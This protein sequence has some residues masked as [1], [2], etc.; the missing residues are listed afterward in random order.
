MQQ[1]SV[2]RI[3][4]KC[5]RSYHRFHSVL[6]QNDSLLCNSQQVDD[7]TSSEL[8]E[9]SRYLVTSAEKCCQIDFYVSDLVEMSKRN[10]S[11][12]RLKLCNCCAFSFS[13]LLNFRIDTNRHTLSPILSYGLPRHQKFSAI[14]VI[15]RKRSITQSIIKTRKNCRRP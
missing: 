1:L 15:L 13:V 8:F 7:P 14:N 2:N 5:R 6:S 9:I 12:K 3:T 4:L 11:Y 10:K